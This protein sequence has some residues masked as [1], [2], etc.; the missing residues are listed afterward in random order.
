MRL[1]VLFEKHCNRYFAVPTDRDLHK[2]CVKIFKERLKGGLYNPGPQPERF[3]M[4][5]DT[6]EDLPFGK[7]KVECLKM[8]EEY[9]ARCRDWTEAVAFKEKVTQ[10]IKKP[11]P[12][13]PSLTWYDVFKN[14]KR[15]HKRRAALESYTLLSSREEYEYERFQLV[16]TEDLRSP[17]G[18]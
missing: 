16:E 17:R 5:L 8:L 10:A 11:Y 18:K 12:K 6:I 14:G 7:L 3:G 1:L 2:A 15:V 9:K 4:S 13:N